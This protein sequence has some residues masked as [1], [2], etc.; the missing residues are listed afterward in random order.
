MNI[1]I[2]NKKRREFALET[3]Q[4]RKDGHLIY[5]SNGFAFDSK[6]TEY[7]RN[8]MVMGAHKSGKT[9]GFVAYNLENGMDS[10][11]VLDKQNNLRKDFV[12]KGQYEAIFYLDPIHGEGTHN[13]FCYLENQED[14][15]NFARAL[16]R[17]VVRSHT[18]ASKHEYWDNLELQILTA[19]VK[20]IAY[21]YGFNPAICE[22]VFYSKNFR[23]LKNLVLSGN[24]VHYV[25]QAKLVLGEVP[26]CFRVFEEGYDY[27][28][29]CIGLG[30]NVQAAITTISIKLGN[31][32]TDKLLDMTDSC[33]FPMN[34]FLDTNEEH[35]YGLF[36]N[37]DETSTNAFSTL[38]L[39]HL[40]NK[41]KNLINEQGRKMTVKST[42]N[43]YLDNLA[44]I[45]K[46]PGA[47]QLFVASRT[48][49]YNF[50][51]CFHNFTELECKYGDKTEAVASTCKFIL[52]YPFHQE[53]VTA[54][55]VKEKVN[56]GNTLENTE[57]LISYFCSFE[58]D[59]QKVFVSTG[60]T[61]SFIDETL[62]DSYYDWD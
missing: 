8:V 3:Y 36:I 48:S 25:K 16:H 58:D 29:K 35:R 47:T 9:R 26:A 5:L 38:V 18:D 44:N 20:F 49:N 4:K 46:L 42:V 10:F 34:K 13:P 59:K 27:S 61:P 19:Y 32:L 37:T 2:K 41:M 50:I 52:A 21:G 55:F 23:G 43:F 30:E 15:A 31:F 28:G 33:S 24:M 62:H 14:V 12:N 22:N 56:E 45:P 54:Q 17:L 40:A 39:W 1:S 60:D 7:C 51:L 57:E 6:D 11:V 53:T